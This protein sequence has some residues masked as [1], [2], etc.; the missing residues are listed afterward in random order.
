[1]FSLIV[2]GIGIT[3]LC[4]IGIAGIIAYF[5]QYARLVGTLT[6]KCIFVKLSFKCRS[7]E[8]L[9]NPLLFVV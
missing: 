1:M 4:I 3:A 8:S 6:P 2:S 7:S 5:V 9:Y